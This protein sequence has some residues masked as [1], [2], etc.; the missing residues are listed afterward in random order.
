MERVYINIIHQLRICSIALALALAA[1]A[2]RG[3]FALAE[4]SGAVTASGGEMLPGVAVTARDVNTGNRR[5]ATTSDTGTY[6]IA[7]LRPGT[8][9]VTFEHAGF[10]TVENR[11]VEMRVGQTTRLMATLRP[12]A[13]SETITVRARAH[14]IDIAS[15][16]VGDTLTAEDLLDLPTQ[17]RNFVLFAALVPGVIPNPQTGSES[18]DALYINGQHQANNSFRVD[19]G[20]ND[21]PLAGSFGGAQ[22]RTAIE[23]IQEF[24]VLTAQYDAEFGSATGGVLNAITKSGTNEVRGSAFI[25][26]QNAKWNSMD[27]FTRREGLQRPDAAFRSQGFTFGGPIVRDRLHYFISFE[28]S[29]D[30]QGQSRFFATRPSLSYS[31][32]E[33]NHLLNVLGR[34]D[35]E[36]ARNQHFSLR[37]LSERAPQFNKIVGAQTALENAREE[38]DFDLNAIAA[39]ESVFGDNRLNSVRVSYTHEHFINASSPSGHWARDFE[40]LRSFDPLQ[41]RPSVQEGPSILGQNQRDDSTDIEDTVSWVARDHEIRAGFQWA[42]RAVDVVNFGQANGRFEFDTDR[43]FNPDDVTTYPVDFTIRVHGPSRS[44]V[45]NIDVL[46]VFA[47][48]Q[49]RLRNNLTVNGGLRW[50]RDDAVH[51]RNNFAPRL[52]FAWSPGQSAR[53]VVR[54]GFG[55]FYD[56]TKLLLWSQFFLD[57]VRFTNGFG[58]RIPDAGTNRQYFVDLVKTNNI[59]TLARLRDLLRAIAEQTSVQLNLNPTVDNP[60]RVQPYVD[61]ASLGIQRELSSTIAAGVDFIHSESKRTLVLVDLNPFSRSRGGRPN[62]SILDGKPVRIG[63]ISTLVNAGSSRYD[64]VQLSVH[65]RLQGGLA[66]RIA[67]TYSDSSGNY[68]NAGPFGAPNTAYFQTRSES[69]YNFDTGEIIGEPLKLNLD[70][71][72]SAGQPVG[73]RRRHNFVIASAWHVPHTR[74]S[75]SSIYRYMSGDRFTVVTTDLLDNGNR[76]PGGPM[77][78]AENPDFRRLDLSLRYAIPISRRSAGVTLIGEVFNLTNRTNFVNAGGMVAGTSGFLIP[79]ATFSPREFQLG[80]RLSF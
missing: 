44:Q 68:G 4:L 35:D 49:W 79:T 47:Q 11:G 20:R 51:D 45:S 80:A 27:F 71:P 52:G 59:T 10:T 46:G 56:E 54:G 29:L 73:W 38:H 24:E 67:Y 6:A 75:V 70:N 64:A 9:V 76:A 66:F 77:F 41:V 74:L 60:S 15:S 61:T 32:T 72:L 5:A 36:L 18:S 1:A 63:S 48:D 14:L 12:A 13:I 31:T 62:I 3:Q 53:T 17:N 55:R 7:G 40:T 57:A 28:Q 65:K 33:E 39:L 30:R 78:G 34:A 43:P 50:D 22:V 19:G 25:F 58:V 16:D 2:A 37:Y 21:D 8:Y 42:R 23:A 69:G 26:F